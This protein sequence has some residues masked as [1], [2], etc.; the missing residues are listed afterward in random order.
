MTLLPVDWCVCRGITVEVILCKYSRRGTRGGDRLSNFVERASLW[1]TFRPF[2]FSSSPYLSFFSLSFPFERPEA[3]AWPVYSFG[4][5]RLCGESP[6]QKDESTGQPRPGGDVK[7]KAPLRRVL[8]ISFKG[9]LACGWV[10][11]TKA[12]AAG[13]RPRLRR[14]TALHYV[15]APLGVRTPRF[16]RVQKSR[17]PG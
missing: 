8:A 7:G 17:I 9:V 1:Q 2:L 15:R 14:R 6:G 11:V 13:A 4:S 10:L 16:C 12:R 5:G 3:S